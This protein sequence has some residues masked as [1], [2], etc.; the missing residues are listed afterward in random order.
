MSA[1]KQAALCVFAVL[2]MLFVGSCSDSQPPAR[3]AVQGVPAAAQQANTRGVAL[4]GRFDYAGGVSAFQEAVRSHPEWVLARLNLAIATL[5]RQEAGDSKAASEL[6]QGVLGDDPHN[7]VAQYILG[8][9]SFNEGQ[10][11]LSR[12]HFERVTAADAQDAYGWYFLGQSL[13]QLGQLEPARAAY[14]QAVALDPYLRSGYYGAFIANQR[15]KQTQAARIFLEAYQKLEPNPR[16]R[17][18][19]IKYT[20]MGSK[21]LVRVDED[22]AG[23]PLES[24]A[25][26]QGELFRPPVRVSQSQIPA[27][28]FTVVQ[29]GPGDTRVYGLGPDAAGWQVAE[30][31]QPAERPGFLGQSKAVSWGDLDNDGDVDA[32]VIDGDGVLALWYQ[33]D[34]QFLPA[35]DGPKTS[36]QLSDVLL[37]DA[38]HDGDLDVLTAGPDTPHQ[39]M[40]NLR[41]GSYRVENIIENSSQAGGASV[42]PADLDGDD[43][44][45]LIWFGDG[46]G[47]RVYLNDRLWNYTLAPAVDGFQAQAFDLIVAG[48]LDADGE[49][50]LLA[51]NSAGLL[52]RWEAASSGWAKTDTELDLTGAEKLALQDFDGDGVAD[53][54]VVWPQRLTIVAEGGFGPALFQSN[55]RYLGTI[56]GVKGP[57]LLVADAGATYHLAAGPARHG[58]VLL[59]LSGMQDEGASM[60]SNASA[61]GTRVALRSSNRWAVNW[62]LRNHSGPGSNLLPAAI[63]LNGAQ[64]ADFVAI[65]WPDGVYQTEL[66]L[67]AGQTHRI[68]ETQRQLASCPVLFAWDGER[69]AFVSDVLGVGGMGFGVGRGTYSIPRPWERFQLPAALLQPTAG[70]Y[71]LKITEPMEEAAY[72]DQVELT[73]YDL[74]PGVAM[75]LDERMGT[76]APEPSG[77]VIAMTSEIAPSRATDGQG[78]DVLAQLSEADLV[79][80][81]PGIPDRR[82][83]G[84]M[85]TPFELTIAFDQDLGALAAPVLVFDGWVEYG[86]SQTYFAAWQAGITAE[87]VSLDILTPGGWQSWLPAWGYPAGMPRSGSLPLGALPEGTTAL[88]L[89][90]NQEIYWDKLVVAEAELDVPMQTHHL[91]LLGAM[92]S[93][94]G[95]PVRTDRSQRVPSY[96][97]NQREPFWDAEYQEGFYTA[98]GPASELVQEHDNNLAIIGPGDE[99]ELRFD[100]A[101]PALRKGWTRTFVVDLKGW[102]KDMD[103]YTRDGQTLSPLPVDPAVPAGNRELESVFNTRFQVGR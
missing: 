36:Q 8:I 9:L 13:F 92:V 95:F 7:L 14:E 75:V 74:P 38:D 86:Y 10:V 4:M 16:A 23:E 25:K 3:E 87:S 46:Q 28:Q 33:T 35:Q 80:V 40:Y 82:F 18:A 45:D 55:V 71:V 89:K 15:L 53:L 79:A 44:L 94:T 1:T 48:D 98:L 64:Q 2:V 72:I 61:V 85:T 78:R 81:D 62:H 93:K 77:A 20:K 83:A 37:V 66:D 57:E 50:D 31:F 6:A 63:G 12:Q 90:T 59:E 21:A 42:L 51:R 43:D 102:A 47:P 70:R 91:A 54:L 76:G 99:L 11:E 103:L 56:N 73:A 19:E 68:K 65:D 32:A 39:L 100:S 52:Q 96:D 34:G 17:L 101:L 30:E 84:L 67:A 5:N 69:H 41:N 26:P 97:Y 22:A 29:F 49:V 58:F 60:R 27:H 24:P 88:R